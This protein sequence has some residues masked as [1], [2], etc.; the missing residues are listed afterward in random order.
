[1]RNNS[2]P[3][4][5]TALG[6]VS[7]FMALFVTTSP[8]A[9]SAVVRSPAT[10]FAELP[11]PSLAASASNAFPQHST[12]ESRSTESDRDADLQPDQ[13]EGRAE[14]TRTGAASAEPV[15]KKQRPVIRLMPLVP[16]AVDVW[17]AEERYFNVSG[18]T[19]DRIVASA[20]ANVPADPT[21][22]DRHSM[23][24]AGPVVWDHRPSY[25]TGTNG[26]CTMTGVASTTR[27]Q[28]TLPQWTSRSKVPTELV[29]WWKVVLDHIRRHESEHIR[30]FEVFVSGLSARVAGQPCSSWPTIVETW[31][32]DLVRAQGA[33][34]AAES[35][36][37]PQRYTGPMQWTTT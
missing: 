4:I 17:N 37:A 19:P 26:S 29:A 16:L 11:T 10:S 7:L 30:I 13:R 35:E 33:F 9:N 32:A 15:A 5:L 31:T 3:A 1:M 36:W 22:A 20:Q 2:R 34:D 21:G 25:V 14:P 28:A 8:R 6:I 23:A 12:F 27:Y 18:G 24:Y